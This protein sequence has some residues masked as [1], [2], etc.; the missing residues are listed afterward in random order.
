M[1]SKTVAPFTPKRLSASTPQGG[2]NKRFSIGMQAPKLPYKKENLVTEEGFL[3]AF[4][5]CIKRP[6]NRTPSATKRRNINVNTE[7]RS[8]REQQLR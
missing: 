4:R 7:D 6:P 3:H 1:T 8:Y 2:A 5:T